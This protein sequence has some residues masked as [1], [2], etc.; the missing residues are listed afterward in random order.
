[1]NFFR[2]NCKTVIYFF[3]IGIVI[4][5]IPHTLNMLQNKKNVRFELL[6]KKISKQRKEKVCLEKSD[7]SKFF[8][9]GFEETAQKRLIACMKKLNFAQ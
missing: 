7:F 5:T 8:E 4:N 9:M 1:M 3:C 2:K 6:E